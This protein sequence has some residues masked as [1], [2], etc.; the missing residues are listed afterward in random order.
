MDDEFSPETTSSQAARD[1]D[2]DQHQL[3]ALLDKFDNERRKAR[4]IKL[5]A[6]VSHGEKLAK[7]YQAKVREVFE[8]EEK[9]IDKRIEQHRQ[10]EKRLTVQIRDTEKKLLEGIAARSDLIQKVSEAVVREVS[11]VVKDT[12]QHAEAISHLEEKEGTAIEAALANLWTALSPSSSSP[13]PQNSADTASKAQ[14]VEQGVYMQGDEQNGALAG[15]G[16]GYG[17]GY[18]FGFGRTVVEGMGGGGGAEQQD[19]SMTA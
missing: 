14:V 17:Y 6:V 4:R 7:E 1:A 19:E 10:D 5:Q 13:A 3:A 8:Q 18:G 9:E 15:A 12:R 11:A 16:G 2:E